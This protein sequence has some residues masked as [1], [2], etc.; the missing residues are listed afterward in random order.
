MADAA[1]G[2]VSDYAYDVFGE[3]RGQSGVPGDTMLFTGEQYD[4][5][6]RHNA[7]GLYYLRARYY[8]PTIGRFL[9]QDPV[10]AGN[11][12]PYVG[13][14]PVN[15][16]DP[17]GL[18]ALGLPCPTDIPIPP[19]PP[20]HPIVTVVACG[21]SDECRSDV[22]DWANTVAD[23]PGSVIQQ[24][25]GTAVAIFSSGDVRR[26]NGVTFY[27]NCWG[28]C[29]MFRA[30]PKTRNIT[31]GHFVFSRGEPDFTTIQH[32]LVHVRQG[33]KYG[34]SWLPR[35]FWESWR[36]GYECNRFEEEARRITGDPSMCG[37]E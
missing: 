20:I 3:L 27:E 24:T 9:S 1:G 35:Y 25:A 12:Y 7:G 5:R 21:I 11:A 26:E 4:A 8:D 18:C 6:A 17:S 15:L 19:P 10:P 31:V 2:V 22:I 29:W 14:N 28:A 36:R 32:E 23:H 16:T 37:K 13:G 30:F 33:D 34:P